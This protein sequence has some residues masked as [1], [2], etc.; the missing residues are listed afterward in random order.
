MNASRTSTDRLIPF[1]APNLTF[2][3]A[4]ALR[5]R[6]AAY[7]KGVRG[8][9]QA[10]V[11]EAQIVRYFRA[12][13]PEFVRAQITSALSEGTVQIVRRS[14]SSTRRA[15]GAYRYITPANGGHHGPQ[16]L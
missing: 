3:G 12:T 8:E 7:V 6:I 11:S 14:L 5:R 10:P 9:R 13:D 16:T 1:H 4:L 15:T 2:D